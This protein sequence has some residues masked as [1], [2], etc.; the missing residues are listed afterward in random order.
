MPDHSPYARRL[1]EIADAL[2]AEFQPTDESLTP[3]PDTLND[4]K[5]R[6]L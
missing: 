3:H 6:L 2:N 1:R 4:I 5:G